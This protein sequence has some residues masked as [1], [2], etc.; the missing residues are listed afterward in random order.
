MNESLLNILYLLIGLVLAGVLF[1]WP[2]L[3]VVLTVSSLA[4][5]DLLPSFGMFDTVLP[6]VGGLSFGGF[7][8]QLLNKRNE[9]KFQIN[10]VLI[11]GLLFIIWILASNTSAALGSNGRNWFFTF[12][13]LWILMLLASKLLDTPEKHYTLMWVFSAVAILS[14]FYAIQSGNIAETD[15]L[16]TNASGF[17]DNANTA[18]RLFTVAMVFLSY[19]R[20]LK[21]TPIQR[22]IA[23]VGIF[24]TYIGVFFTVSRTGI[25][26]LFIAQ[27]FLFLFQSSGKQRIRIIFS[28]V[29]GAVLLWL[30]VSNAF[31]LAQTI[32]PTVTQGSDT[33]GLRYSLWEAGW[34]MFTDK[35]LS[36]VGIGN[37][38]GLLQFYGTGLPF[39]ANRVS[40]AH[41]TY[42]QIL[43]ETGIVGFVLFMSMFF[44]TFHNFYI[45]LKGEEKNTL[46]VTKVWLI[47]FLIML[48]GGLTK[49]DHADK[50]TWAVMG[51]SAFFAN[52]SCS[53]QEKPLKG[54]VDAPKKLR[55]REISSVRKS[56]IGK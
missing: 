49:S 32:L 20:T 21:I 51:I 41:N 31:V 46:T 13:Q 6:V 8:I 17:T 50:L 5:I 43:S 29:F 22:V 56:S 45:S 14:A 53:P 24:T 37:F 2:Y 11:F 44:F 39:L 9:K 40:W 3:G 42:V 55:G 38:I 15:N 4:I 35:P 33:M 1:K 36:G 7:I 30:F 25:V 10:P 27:A 34:R 26:L 28:A 52:Q 19:L 48:I 18:A 47:T 12:S 54:T 23:T 16:S